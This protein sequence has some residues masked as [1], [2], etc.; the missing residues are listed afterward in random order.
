VITS[1]P[2]F[3]D[4]SCA[5]TVMAFAPDTSAMPATLQLDVPTAV[6]EPPVAALTHVTDVTL[7]LSEAVPPRSTLEDDVA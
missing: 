1:V 5:A 4:P 3:P 7:T 6:P 2:T